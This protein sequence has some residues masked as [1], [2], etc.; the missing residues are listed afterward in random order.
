MMEWAGLNVWRKVGMKWELCKQLIKLHKRHA[1]TPK[2]GVAMLTFEITM[3]LF[4]PTPG[5]LKFYY[6][7]LD[8]KVVD[9]Y[10]IVSNVTV[11]YVPVRKMYLL[12][13]IDAKSL[14]EF[15]V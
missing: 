13:P 4:P 6:D 8:C 15:V 3:Y 10:S 11:E 9:A 14:D 2:K 7:Q 12:D 1:T 5:Y